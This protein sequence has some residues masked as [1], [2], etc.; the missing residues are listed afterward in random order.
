MA[1]MDN[2]TKSSITYLYVRYGGGGSSDSNT[3]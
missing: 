1:A 3:A 2:L